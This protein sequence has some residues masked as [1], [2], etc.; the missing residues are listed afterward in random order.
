MKITIAP[1][2]A[3][4]PAAVRIAGDVDLAST[5]PFRRVAQA[6]SARI[7]PDLQLDLAGVTFIDC[8]GLGALEEWGAA[9]ARR[10][11][12]TVLTDVSI[13]VRRVLA[14]TWTTLAEWAPPAGF[15]P[16]APGT[17]NQCSIP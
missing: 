7:S 5:L 6:L 11:G 3:G 1:D 16:A 14:M 12:T 15:E 13:D 2:I 10:G 17:G 4:H 8:A 9:V